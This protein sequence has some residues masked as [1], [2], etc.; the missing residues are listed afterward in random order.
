MHRV[1]R[2]YSLVV[3]TAGNFLWQIEME[4]KMQW[5]YLTQ[6]IVNSEG[7]KPFLASILQQGYKVTIL[8]LIQTLSTT[9]SEADIDILLI[10]PSLT[11][12]LG[13]QKIRKPTSCLHCVKNQGFKHSEA[14]L[15]WYQRQL[16]RAH[17]IRYAPRA[18]HLGWI[19]LSPVS[20][21]EWYVCTEQV[22]VFDK[23]GCIW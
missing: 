20:K 7:E 19:L 12:W 9:S 15:P 23:H 22:L 17:H 4:K 18:H 6:W 8:Y 14:T 21:Q 10:T 13:I 3:G 11:W 2:P 16:L 5:S 1:W